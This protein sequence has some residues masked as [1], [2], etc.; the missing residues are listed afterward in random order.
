MKTFPIW[1]P[2]KSEISGDILSRFEKHQT[3]LKNLITGSKD[4]LEKR[5]VISSPANKNIVYNKFPKQMLKLYLI[6][7]SVQC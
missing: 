2:A 7:S 1:E 5:T 6:N 3:D 4:L